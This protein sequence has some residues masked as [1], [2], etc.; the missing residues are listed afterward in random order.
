MSIRDAQPRPFAQQP[1]RY[2]RR[3]HGAIQTRNSALDGLRGVAA[4]AVLWS[5]VTVAFGLL[6][7]SPL[8]GMG[9]L[10]FFALSGYLIA[11]IV[12]RRAG[13]SGAYLTFLRRRAVRLA[14]AI[15]ALSVVGPLVL[16][17][18]QSADSVSAAQQGALVLTQT[19]AFAINA[20]FPVH[21]VLGPT[22]SLTVEWVFYLS[23]PA[24]LLCMLQ[25]RRPALTVARDSA[26]M[27]VALYA[28]SLL[29]DPQAFYLLPV[30]N[31]AVMML[32]AALGLAHHAGW[33]SPERLR[34][35]PWPW[36]G[37]ALILILVFLPGYSLSWGY[38]LAVLPGTALATMLVINGCVAGHRVGNL[39]RMG[40]LPA[41]GLR[42]YSLY[43][44]H[45]SVLWVTWTASG[46]SRGSWTIALLGCV[47]LVPVVE[48]SYRLFEM[49]VLRGGASAL[50]PAAAGS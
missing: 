5:H 46:A 42:A 45:M 47:L 11:R 43:L 7:F 17:A 10:V 29:L 15:V 3:V 48:V 20:G 28:V 12:A 39:L 24:Y 33:A 49:P 34:S 23:F 19:A 16:L 38:K 8:G 32:G 14:P 41:I 25:L 22:W 35:G 31:L 18:T 6:P 9:V 44:W 1:S 26:A 40:F 13:E 4:L 27:A 36:A 37:A 30:A 2:A 21:P 50:Q